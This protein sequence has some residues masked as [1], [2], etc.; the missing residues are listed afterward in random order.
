MEQI[1]SFIAIELPPEVR[2]ALTGLQA[3]LKAGD[4]RQVKW[5]EPENMHLTLQFL[6][7]I[8]AGIVDNIASA[9]RQAAIGTHPFQ[10]EVGG[11]GVFPNTQRVSVIWVGLTGDMEKLV[12]LQK[13]IG[14]NLAPLGFKP[15]TRP[16]TPH[17]TLGRV[18]DYCRPPERAALG[19]VIARTAF[20][21]KYRV[22]V[23]AVNLM[24]SRLTR[25]GPIYSR[26]A[27]VVLK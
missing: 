17:L 21:N 4:G 13:S 20:N 11:L 18:K 26:L 7:N 15:E 27:A 5:V 9:I 22:T 25:E 6:G 2:Q 3:K 19:Q 8:D 23:T 16:F 14:A 1:R 10:L 24:Q 12:G